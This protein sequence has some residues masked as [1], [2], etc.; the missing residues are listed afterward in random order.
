MKKVIA[1]CLAAL[2]LACSIPALA[3]E[4]PRLIRVSGNAVVSL[5]ADTATLEQ[6]EPHFGVLLLVVGGFLENGGYLL[7]TIFLGL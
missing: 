1:L 2:L 3:E 6:F 4:N 7:V 5:A